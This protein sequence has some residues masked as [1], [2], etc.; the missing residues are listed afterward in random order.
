M[1]PYFPADQQRRFLNA[2]RLF[3][4]SNILK[5]LRHLKPELCDDAMRTLIYQPRCG[6]TTPSAGVAASSAISSAQLELDT[7]ELNTVLHHLAMCRQAA[8]AGASGSVAAALPAGVLDDACADLDVTSSNQ[9][10]LLSAEHEVVDALYANQEA[11]AAILHADG[12]HNQDESQREHHHGQPQQLYDYFY[13]D[14]TAGDD[15]SSKPHLDINVDGMQHFDF[16]TNYDAEHKV[17]LTSDHQMPVGVDEHN[18]ID[19]KGFEIKSGPSLVDVFDLRQEEEQVQTVDVNTDIE[20]KEMVDMN[21]DI[22]VK[23]MVDENSNIDIIKTMVDVNADIVDVVKTVVDVNGD[24][25]VKE[26]LPELDNGK[27]IAGDATQMAE[28]SHCRLGLGVSSF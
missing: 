19:D 7:A 21:A 13:Y 20:V 5:T 3:G 23:T 14:S 6:P 22:D 25:G 26:E 15:V 9:P 27:I 16:D 11:D 18:Q 28:S 4:V 8:A 2:H 1:A 12:H 24:I 17:E 10:L